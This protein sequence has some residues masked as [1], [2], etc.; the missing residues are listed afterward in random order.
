MVHALKHC[1]LHHLQSQC[2]LNTYYMKH[3]GLPNRCTGGP[4]QHRAKL[5]DRLAGIVAECSV[6]WL[7][8]E[9]KKWHKERAKT[10][11]LVFCVFSCAKFLPF[12]F[13]TPLFEPRYYKHRKVFPIYVW[14]TQG[15]SLEEFLTLGTTELFAS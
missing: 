6:P 14:S 3:K 13:P 1:L 5:R 8:G 2:A 15:H 12:F 11:V 7:E 9:E 10:Q 4:R